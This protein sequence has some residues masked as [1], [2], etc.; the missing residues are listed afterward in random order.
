MSA[1]LPTNTATA[2][3]LAAAYAPHIAGKTI[4]TT[5]VSPAT[6]GAV[7]V[8]ALAS[9]ASPATF[10]LT[11]RSPAKLRQTADALVALNPAAVVKTVVFD[12]LSL[13]DVRRAA[14]EVIAWDDVPAIDVVVNNAGIMAVDFGLTVDG[15]E[16]HLAANHLAHF[17]FTN[18]LMPKILAAPSPRIVNIASDGHR[19]S[20]IRWADYNFDN[21][22]TYHK[23]QAYGQ[24]KTSNMLFSKGLAKRLGPRGLLAFSVHPGLIFSTQLAGHLDMSPDGDMASLAALDRQL[25][26]AAGWIT[27]EDVAKVQVSAEVGSA[28][29]VFASFEPSLTEH[30]GKY[31][32]DARVANPYKDDVA[33]WAISEIEADK[34]WTLSEKLVGEDFSY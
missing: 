22:N 13:A 20:P 23:W 29:H 2:R 30:N 3:D 21:G 15:V 5:G 19:L 24:S 31:L 14:A 27:P 7:F 18:L 16:K 25:G 11:G 33:P 26:N 32:L 9:S 28:T 10:I 8:E 6:L 4:L 1:A 12:M 17:L 34:L